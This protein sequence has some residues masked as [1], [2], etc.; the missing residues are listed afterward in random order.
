[1]LMWLMGW[2]GP[3]SYPGCMFPKSAFR[4]ETKLQ[5]VNLKKEACYSKIDCNPTVHMEGMST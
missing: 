3:G 5:T 4:H 1:M 2:Y